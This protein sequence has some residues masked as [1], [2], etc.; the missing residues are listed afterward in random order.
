[1][2]AATRASL[3]FGALAL[4]TLALALG[5]DTSAVVPGAS[6]KDLDKNQDGRVSMAEAQELPTLRSSFAAL[7]RNQDGYLSATEFTGWKIDATSPGR[8]STDR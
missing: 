5:A 6:F 7:D 3:I 1:M 2:K 4:S 8:S